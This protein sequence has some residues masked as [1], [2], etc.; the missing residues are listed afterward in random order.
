MRINFFSLKNEGQIFLASKLY[1]LKYF[2]F[3]FVF[4]H[5]LDTFEIILYF[6]PQRNNAIEKTLPN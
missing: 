4:T 6:P 1:F 3:I 5:I 2:K